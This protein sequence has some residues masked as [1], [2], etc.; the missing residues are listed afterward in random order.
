MKFQRQRFRGFD[1]AAKFRQGGGGGAR[2]Y[3][4]VKHLIL[5]RRVRWHSGQVSVR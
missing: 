4:R 5:L 2:P 1:A 3:I